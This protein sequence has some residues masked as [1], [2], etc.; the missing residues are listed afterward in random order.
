MQ[1]KAIRIQMILATFLI[2]LGIA[3][4]LVGLFA[5]FLAIYIV[6]VKKEVMFALEMTLGCSIYLS[7]GLCLVLSGKYLLKNRYR[8]TF[9]LFAGAIIIFLTAFHFS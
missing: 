8:W 4:L 2:V 5:S 7:V 3:S 9:S 1:L 6:F